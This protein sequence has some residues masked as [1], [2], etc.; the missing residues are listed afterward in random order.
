[1]KVGDRV[2]IMSLM[3]KTGG[4]M[5]GRIVCEVPPLRA[6]HPEAKFV[7][8]NIDSTKY[9]FDA[10]DRGTVRDEISFVVKLDLPNPFDAHPPPAL[11]VLVWPKNDSL[12]VMDEPKTLKPKPKVNKK[13]KE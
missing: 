5:T 6:P 4:A 7:G 11:P 10:I 12:K 1:M 13:D 8:V 2:Q 9:D 3:D